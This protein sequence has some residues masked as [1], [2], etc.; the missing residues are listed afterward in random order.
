[1]LATLLDCMSPALIVS[2]ASQ[3]V[4]SRFDISR[5][6]ITEDFCEEA[7]GS[8]WGFFF[9]KFNLLKPHFYWLGN[10]I[11]ISFPRQ[12]IA[13]SYFIATQ[14]QSSVLVLHLLAPQQ[15]LTRIS[16]LLT[17]LIKRQERARKQMQR[18]YPTLLT[19]NIWW[20]CVCNEMKAD[21]T[22]PEIIPKLIRKYSGDDL[23]F[24]TAKNLLL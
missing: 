22:E 10:Y 6:K 19:I 7:R 3:K 11:F 9:T 1:M 13:T 14:N 2:L 4:L 18:F 8:I 23:G 20:S 16:T 21:I 24:T 17:V 15:Q 12:T 5:G